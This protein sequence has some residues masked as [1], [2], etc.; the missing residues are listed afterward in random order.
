MALGPHKVLVFGGAD[1]TPQGF[2]DLWLLELAE[3]QQHWT[4]ITPKLGAGQ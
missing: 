1:R 3:G 4:K 2:G